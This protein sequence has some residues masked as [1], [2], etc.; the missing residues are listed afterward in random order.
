MDFIFILC[1][2]NLFCWHGWHGFGLYFVLACTSVTSKKVRVKSFMKPLRCVY[3]V[4][5]QKVLVHA[6]ACLFTLSYIDL[7]WTPNQLG[8]WKQT[9]FGTKPSFS[10]VS[11]QLQK[12]KGKLRAV[13]LEGRLVNKVL[14]SDSVG[15]PFVLC[16]SR[17]TAAKIHSRDGR[18]KSWLEKRNVSGAP[19]CSLAAKISPKWRMNEWIWE[20]EGLACS[21]EVLLVKAAGK[22][23]ETNDVY[24]RMCTQPNA[25]GS[26]KEFWCYQVLP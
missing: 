22:T 26:L 24:E 1:P 13:G 15:P 11:P 20:R 25:N 14:C 18:K 7:Y 16:P 8:V 17:V 6:S 4:L 19:F 10:L 12:G 5:Q 2:S 23:R 9:T 3:F 21:V